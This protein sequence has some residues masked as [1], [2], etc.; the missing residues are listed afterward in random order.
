MTASLFT[1]LVDD[2]GLFPPTD[3]PMA[4]ALARHAGDVGNPVVT[5]RFLCPAGRLPECVALLDRP[6]DLG[7]IAP[8][9]PAGLTAA[10]EA[11]RAEPFLRLRSVEGVLPAAL[12]RPIDVPSYAEVVL[13]D[14]LDDVLDCM[15]ASGWRAKLRCGG[16]RAEM[17]PTSEQVARF[18]HGCARRGVAFKATAGLHN[19]VRHRD[20]AT[21][22]E[23]HGFLNLVIA[24]ARAAGGGSSE[25]LVDALRQTEAAPLV[26]EAKALT[27][28]AADATRDLFTCYGSCSTSEPWADLIALDL[29]PAPSQVSA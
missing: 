3:L 2:A 20:P 5:G 15:S 10:L 25:E 19:A 26:A 27:P 4:D 9:D 12:P 23:H 14:L 16:V 22:F 1:A 13:D 24:S 8:L 18:V 11:V 21:G 6:L 7:L 29:L 28:A 17:F